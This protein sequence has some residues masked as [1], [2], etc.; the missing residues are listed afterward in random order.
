MP[1]VENKLRSFS[2]L[3]IKPFVKF[4]EIP[5]LRGFGSLCS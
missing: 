5:E 4:A 2:S 1:N 3:K